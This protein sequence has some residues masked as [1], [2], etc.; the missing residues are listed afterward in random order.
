M[1]TFVLPT[2]RAIRHAQLRFEKSTLFLPNYTTMAEFIERAC[3]VDGYKKIDND[4]RTILLLEASDFQSFS[5]LNIERNFFTFTQN[6][7]YLFALFTELAGEK[8][9]LS[10]LGTADTYGDYEEHITILQA[11]HGR[12]EALCHQRK[13]LDPIFLPKLY[14]LNEDYIKSLGAIELVVEGY[15]TAFEIEILQ[16]CSKLASLKIQIITTSFNTKMQERLL[17]LG[18]TLEAGKKYLLDMNAKKLLQ[19]EQ[20]PIKSELTCNSFSEQ[21]LQVAFVKQKVYAYIQSGL[22]CEEI[23]VI[24]PNESFAELLHLYDTEGN[25]NFAMGTKFTKTHSY[26]HLKAVC[27]YI[28]NPT[29]QNSARLSRY[30]SELYE[31][32]APFYYKRMDSIDFEALM[33]LV[34]DSFEKSAHLY[35]KAEKKILQEELYSFSKLKKIYNELNLKSALYLFMQRVS[36][37]SLDDVRGGKITVMGVLESRNMHY[38]G[39]IIVDFNDANVPKKSEKDLFLNSDIRALAN[40]PTQNDRENLQKHYYTLLMQ[41]AEYVSIASVKSSTAIPSR[42]LTQLGINIKEPE[43]EQHYAQILHKKSYHD[44]KMQEEQII[45]EYDFTRVKLSATSLKSFLECKR[46]YYYRYIAHLNKHELPQDFASENQIGLDLHEALKNLYL[47]KNRFSDAKE[48]HAKL[49]QELQSVCKKSSL[50]EYQLKL[51]SK[52]LDAFVANEIERF[53]SGVHVLECEKLLTCKQFGVELSGQIDRIDRVENGLY[54]LDYKSGKYPAY[55][56]KTLEKATDFQLEFYALLAAGEGSVCGCG[57]Y[58]LSSGKIIDET[59]LA[60]KQH[61]LETHIKALVAQ[62]SFNFSKCEDESL[63]KYCEYATLCGRA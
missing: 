51:W 14:R 36:Q 35:K 32:L 62:K 46:K 9:S 39:V 12:Y 45:Q 33:G 38:R 21:I 37:R 24:V 30:K 27:E 16:K 61:L 55:T 26:K 59:F 11:L 40:L 29:V 41:R 18:F 58:D 15:L 6:S 49:F 1:H 50:E 63:C 22:Q 25:F 28:E 13:I 47:K 48:L 8:V 5:A 19:E 43:N 17:H 3:I 2:A 44:S 4:T 42:F 57:Y 34:M 10:A 52:K 31:V 60:E 7:S 54:V 53:R 23:V 56:A 20:E